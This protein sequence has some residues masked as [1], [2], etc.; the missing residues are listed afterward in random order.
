MAKY[1]SAAEPVTLMMKT[2]HGHWVG[3]VTSRRTI[4]TRSTAPTIPPAKIAASSRLSEPRPPV[5]Q[6]RQAV[7]AL[8][9]VPRPS[10]SIACSRILNFW[11][12]P[13]TVIG[14]PS[15]SLT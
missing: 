14:K 7:R 13:V 3:S 5:T 8:A 1:A 9:A 10:S 12:L 6:P 15:T 11:T 2:A 4:H